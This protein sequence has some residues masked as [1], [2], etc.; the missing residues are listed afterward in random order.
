[1]TDGRSA[2]IRL[3]YADCDPA[4]IVY[5]G[6]WFPIM[7]RL[8]LDWFF[9]G[10]FRFDT[11]LAELGAAPVTRSTSCDYLATARVYDEVEIALT[12]ESIGTS[13]YRLGFAMTRAG[14][15]T[16]LARASISCV[17]V[18]DGRAVALPASVRS[19]LETALV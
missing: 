1:M 7:E 16:P 14:D 9:R 18:A 5:Y 11:I 17:Y 3:S 12:V 2:R 4:G 19:Y 15:S 6:A 10:G 8:L 13:S